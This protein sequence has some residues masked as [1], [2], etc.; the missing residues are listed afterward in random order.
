[1]RMFSSAIAKKRAKVLLLHTSVALVL[2]LIVYL[3]F[4]PDAGI[5]RLIY[6]I[7]GLNAPNITFAEGNGIFLRHY[8]ADFLW[9]YALTIS[10]N[11]ISIETPGKMGAMFA[12]SLFVGCIVELLQGAGI[13]FGTYDPMDIVIQICAAII[14]EAIVL[15]IFRKEV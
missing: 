13:L 6:R 1:M 3:I 12:L 9:A 2:G 4:R 11:L 5:A 10:L 14:A 8:L 15:I 7:P